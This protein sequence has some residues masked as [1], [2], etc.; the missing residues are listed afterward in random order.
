M[1]ILQQR[2][3][4]KRKSR[5]GRQEKKKKITNEW[6]TQNVFS[7]GKNLWFDVRRRDS[8]R[9]R[10]EWANDDDDDEKLFKIRARTKKKMGKGKGKGKGKERGSVGSISSS[11]GVTHSNKNQ[12]S[13]APIPFHFVPFAVVYWTEL[14]T[15][16]RLIFPSRSLSTISQ[17]CTLVMLLLFLF[18]LFLLQSMEWLDFECEERENFSSSSSSKRG[19]GCAGREADKWFRSEITTVVVR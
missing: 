13:R 7:D 19:G 9:G 8:K 5:R 18:L 16:T 14:Y 1:G 11:N 6:Y 12:L 4:W 10:K 2:K 3:C 17:P 15:Y